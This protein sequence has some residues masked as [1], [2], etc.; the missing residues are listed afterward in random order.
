MS[1]YSVKRS[2]CSG[3]SVSVWRKLLAK[4]D[5][6][7]RELRKKGFEYVS[8]FHRGDLMNI[9]QVDEERK[10]LEEAGYDVEIANAYDTDG[11]YMPESN[12]VWRKKK[13]RRLE[14]QAITDR[15]KLAALKQLRVQLKRKFLDSE[16]AKIIRQLNDVLGIRGVKRITTFQKALDCIDDHLDASTYFTLIKEKE[17]K[18]G[19]CVSFGERIGNIE[20]ISWDGHLRLSFRDGKKPEKKLVSP[21]LVEAVV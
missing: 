8:N 13:K 19:V 3:Y 1:V 4:N 14:G 11:K 16:R 12:S 15:E 21:F 6:Q 10:I 2:A 5:G 20:S 17:F 9:S 18:E 7:F